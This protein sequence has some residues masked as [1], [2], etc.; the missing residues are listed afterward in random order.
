MGLFAS[1]FSS[2]S[3]R[4]I[5]F[6]SYIFSGP[7][8]WW[9]GWVDTQL[10]IQLQAVHAVTSAILCASVRIQLWSSRESQVIT[11]NY[12]TKSSSYRR[13]TSRQGKDCS[14]FH[15]SVRMSWRLHPLSYIV[16]VA[17]YWTSPPTH[18]TPRDHACEDLLRHG[19][20]LL[21]SGTQC[22][23]TRKC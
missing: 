19:A 3:Y 9:M 1:I 11:I 23:V 6:Q 13:T 7:L 10:P 22:S 2:L 5:N 21:I 16:I 12:S 8:F 17:V 20:A 18:L 15:G 4:I 14:A